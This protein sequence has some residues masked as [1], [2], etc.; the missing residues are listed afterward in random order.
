LIVEYL[1]LPE[2]KL[3]SLFVCIGFEVLT[4]VIMKCTVLWVVMIE[5]H[6]VTAQ[7]TAL[8]R[9]DISSPDN[10]GRANFRNVVV[11]KN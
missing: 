1:S 2:D 9:P 5:I 4:E 8:F 6:G 10:G 7:K 11:L 3:I